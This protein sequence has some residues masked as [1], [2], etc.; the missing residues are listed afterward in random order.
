M[1]TIIKKGT[2]KLGYPNYFIKNYQSILTTSK[3]TANEFNDYFVNVGFNLAKDIADPLQRDGVE[4]DIITRNPNTIFLKKVGENE[5]VDVV[6]KLSNKKSTNCTDIDMALVKD[7][8]EYIAK[9]LTY[10]CNQ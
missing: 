4:V 10:I 5:L 6:C 8:I 2:G 3:E 7:I 9:P 1:E